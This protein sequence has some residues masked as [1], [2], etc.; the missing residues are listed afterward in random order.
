VIAGV[1]VRGAVLFS[2]SVWKRWQPKLSILLYS[3]QPPAVADWDGS[4]VDLWVW[5]LPLSGWPASHAVVGDRRFSCVA[6]GV[7][8]IDWSSIGIITVAWIVTR[9]WW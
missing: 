1:G 2:C 9:R 3:Q 4:A 7:Q 6:V 5:L 8:A